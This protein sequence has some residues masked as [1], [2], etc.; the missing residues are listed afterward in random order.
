[1][2]THLIG[3]RLFSCIKNIQILAILSRTIVLI[4]PIFAGTLVSLGCTL[5]PVYTFHKLRKH[6]LDS[7]ETSNYRGE[8]V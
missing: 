4:Y 7:L 5:H 6:F 2:V 1:M 8:N 3:Q